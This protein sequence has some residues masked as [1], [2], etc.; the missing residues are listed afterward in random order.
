MSGR[1]TILDRLR[2][3]LERRAP[4]GHPGPFGPWEKSAREGK[5][6]VD[7]FT[8]MFEEAGGAVVIVPDGAAA[9]AWIIGRTADRRASLTTGARVPAPLRPPLPEAA[10]DEAD[11]G[12]SMARGAVAQTGS[13]IMD[14]RDGRRAQLLAPAHVIVVDASTVHDTLTEALVRLQPD[15]PSAIG[16]HSGPSKSADIGQVMVRGVHGPGEVVALV[17][18]DARGLTPPDGGPVR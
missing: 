17:V 7:R 3:S 9:A 16:L 6:A 14:A 1:T 18:T 2:T 13:L 8:S 4:A 11:V 12:L 15:L 5:S 10:P